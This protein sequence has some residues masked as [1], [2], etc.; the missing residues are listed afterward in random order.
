MPLLDVKLYK[1]RQFLP[2]HEMIIHVLSLI[3]QSVVK[4]FFFY[5]NLFSLQKIHKFSVL[6]LIFCKESPF[7]T[8]P[9]K[10]C[11]TCVYLGKTLIFQFTMYLGAKAICQVTNRSNPWFPKKTREPGNWR[12][13]TKTR[14]PWVFFLN[15]SGGC[16]WL[17]SRLGRGACLAYAFDVGDVAGEGS[18]TPWQPKKSW[19]KKSKTRGMHFQQAALTHGFSHLFFQDEKISQLLGHDER[20]FCLKEKNDCWTELEKKNWPESCCDVEF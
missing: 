16:C 5:H 15:S 3:W 18:T 19:G 4:S 14:R 20:V 2:K 17:P 6:Q 1:V 10:R 7:E 9:N 12:V 13:V 8:P 11:V